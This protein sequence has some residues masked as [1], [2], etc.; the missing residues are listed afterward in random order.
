MRKR[1]FAERLLALF[2]DRARAASIVGDLAEITREKGNAWFWWAYADVFGAAAWRPLAA[3]VFATAATWFGGQYYLGGGFYC[4]SNIY[5]ACLMPAAWLRM[6]IA[7]GEFSS[8]VFLFAAV[9]FGLNDR[10]TRLALGFAVLGSVAGWFFFVEYM[11]AIASTAFAVL[12][13]SALLSPKGRRSLAAIAG[14]W[15]AFYCTDHVGRW[16]FIGV[17]RHVLRSWDYRPAF[18]VWFAICYIGGLAACAA[19]CAHVHHALLDE[20]KLARG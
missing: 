13:G 9:R 20:Q 14:L 6:V 11:V 12:C 4:P 7:A 19:L 1:A 16:I 18:P 2:T 3:F 8:F 15:V 5:A 17:L 10:L